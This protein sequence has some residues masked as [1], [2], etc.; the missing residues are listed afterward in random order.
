MRQS[1]LLNATD[2]L[3]VRPSIPF[4]APHFH[5]RWGFGSVEQG[6]RRLEGLGTISD[7]PHHIVCVADLRAQGMERKSSQDGCLGSAFVDF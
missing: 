6:D 5:V 3:P 1:W 4:C 2:L 7:M